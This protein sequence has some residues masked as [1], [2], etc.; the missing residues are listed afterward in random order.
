MLA[1]FLVSKEKDISVT[2]LQFDVLQDVPKLLLKRL[3]SSHELKI[4]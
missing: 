3:S 2:A 1:N 4:Y